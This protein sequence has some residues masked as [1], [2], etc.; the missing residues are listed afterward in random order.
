M[1][2][3][4][5]II[6]SIAITSS[7]LKKEEILR[8]NKDNDLLQKVLHYTYNPYMKYKITEGVFDNN[9]PTSNT[10]YKD[11]FELLETLAKSNIN[12]KLRADV[13]SFVQGEP[14]LD[15]RVLY[16]FMLTKDLRAGFS[17]S[18]INKIFPKLIPTFKVMLAEKYFDN[19]SFVEGKSFTITMKMDGHRVCAIKEDGVVSLFTRQGQLYTGLVEIEQYL[20][21]LPMD[22]IVIDGELLVS[23]YREIAPN[24]RYKATSKV[25]RKDIPNKTGLS[26]IAF[27]MIPLKDFKR[28]KSAIGYEARRGILENLV[29]ENPSNVIECV[30]KLYVG[31]DTEMITK[32][33]D[34]VVER[35][36]EGVMVNL[37][38]GAYECKRTKQLLKVKKFLIADLLVTDIF[39]GEGMNKGQLGAIE[40][41]FIH[42]EQL[43]RCNCGTGFTQEER[44]LYYNNPEL[45]L[46]KI[47]EIR[48]FEISKNDNGGFGLR[49]PSWQHRIR[50]D[51]DEISMY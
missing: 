49:F 6:N 3:I 24:A 23:N 48:Y 30:E 26:I 40:I 43:H 20:K 16:R 47:C 28:G 35:G 37:N 39:E 21:N 32:L 34:S 15:V 45:I 7:R 14:R 2:E 27:D 1:K 22:N 46:N 13:V 29:D 5:K 44:I 4:S 17:D 12:D 42:N 36:E 19:P 9:Y 33:L 51:K 8:A 41:E 50:D 10:P 38:D 25:A 18:T 11:I 31:T